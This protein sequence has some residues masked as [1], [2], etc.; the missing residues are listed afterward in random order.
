MDVPFDSTSGGRLPAGVTLS[1]VEFPAGEDVMMRVDDLLTVE[2][3][4]SLLKGHPK[5]VRRWCATAR[6]PRPRLAGRE[7]RILRSDLL[8]QRG[9]EK[10]SA[11]VTSTPT[12]AA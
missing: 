1:S 7:Y 6:I 12:V 5:T 11:E 4:A 3:A 8:G 9:P 2:E 10:V